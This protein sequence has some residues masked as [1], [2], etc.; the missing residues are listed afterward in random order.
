M[1]RRLYTFLLYVL[2]PLLVLRLLWRG[3]R[4]P[5]YWRRWPE[6]F[7]WIARASDNC[8]WVHAVSVGEVQAAVPLVK[9]LR[10]RYPQW[11]IVVT[12][13]TPT[14]AERVQAALQQDVSHYYLPY[15]LPGAVRRFVWCLRPRLLI[16]M[17]TELWPNLIHYCHAQNLPIVLANARLSVRSAA[18]YRRVKRLTSEMLTKITVIAAQTQADAARFIELG[19]SPA[20]VRITGNIKYDMKLSASLR[21]QAEVLR[22]SWGVER[23]VWIAA[24]THE[25][26]EQ[27]ILDA[28]AAVR[29]ELPNALLVIVPRHPE[30]FAKIVALCQRQGYSIVRRSEQRACD[31]A[32]EIVIGDSMG[33]LNLFYAASDIAF[34]GGSLVATG[35]HNL[36]E[37]AAQGVAIITGPHTFNFSEVAEQLCDAGAAVRIHNTQELGDTVTMYLRDAN[38]RYQTGQKG[39]QLVERNRGALDALLESASQ[40]IR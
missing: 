1:T 15:D 2:A 17:E 37:P 19:A 27:Q 20:S 32:T 28:Y 24:S 6:R 16:I 36:I 14:G 3:L 23:A 39:K 4:A 22:R 25:G 40:Y 7:G 21:E 18:R 30:R 31:A 5:A 38:L 12:T 8:L 11:R 29:R 26:E 35:G 34:V 33:E 13:M 9:V 10:A